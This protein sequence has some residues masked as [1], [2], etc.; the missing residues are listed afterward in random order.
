MFAIRDGEEDEAPSGGGVF[1]SSFLTRI[2]DLECFGTGTDGTVLSTF[3][4]M[5][6]YVL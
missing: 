4:L 2:Q 1:S 5:D 6:K 3:E